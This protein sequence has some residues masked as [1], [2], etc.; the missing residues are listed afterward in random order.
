MQ[1]PIPE[2]YSS[3]DHFTLGSDIKAVLDAL[4]MPDIVLGE[5]LHKRVRGLEPGKWYP[6]ELLLE[7]M[8]ALDA[9][10]GRMALLQMGRRLFAASH[11]TRTQ[12]KTNSASDVIF[13][14]DAMYHHANR[15]SNIGGWSV[16]L[17]EPGHARLE[18]R[19]PHH[20]LME[21]GLLSA[22]LAAAGTPSMVTQTQCLR[23]GAPFC[24]FD[25]SSVISDVR[26]SGGHPRITAPERSSSAGSKKAG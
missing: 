11:Q 22:A 2:G 23:L 24:V 8:D 19:T 15:G 16:I 26:W 20:C 18:K 25:V 5:A 17:F 6:I 9:K 10:V 12:E 13:G 4:L 3:S 7:V 21:E 14:I 1:R